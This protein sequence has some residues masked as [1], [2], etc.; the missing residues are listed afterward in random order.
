[1]Q[2]FYL[3]KD[4]LSN[5]VVVKGYPEDDLVISHVTIKESCGKPI[6]VTFEV[7]TGVE[8]GH[9]KVDNNTERLTYKGEEINRLRSWKIKSDDYGQPTFKVTLSFPNGDTC[10]DKQPVWLEDKIAQDKMIEEF[11]AKA[12]KIYPNIYL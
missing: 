9:F 7:V 10:S 2:N 3:H 6:I 12:S 8:Q 1:M 5:H 11:K 4:P